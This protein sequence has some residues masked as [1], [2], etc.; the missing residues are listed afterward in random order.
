MDNL[1]WTS[2]GDSH[3]IEPP[4]PLQERLPAALADRLPALGEGQRR[5]GDRAHR[6]PHLPS[7]APEAEPSPSTARGRDGVPEGMAQGGVG[8]ATA[9]P[10]WSTSTTRASGAR[11]SSR[12]SGCGTARSTTPHLVAG[13]GQGAQRLRE[14]GAHRPLAALRAH[15]HA[16][17]AVGGALHD[18][19]R[20]RAPASASSPSS[21]PPEPRRVRP[22]LERRPLGAALDR[23][24][25]RRPGGRRTTSARTPRAPGRSG[26]P[27]APC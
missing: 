10:A 22:L 14:R 13:G 24:R 3:F 17:A 26:T 5:R 1:L 11:S 12:P 8:A 16:A 2:S 25:G 23:A 20:T 7:A 4:E 18:G 19:G 9:R 15:G 6:R 27:A 21:C